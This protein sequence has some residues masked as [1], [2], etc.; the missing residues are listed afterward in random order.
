MVET[1]LMKKTLTSVI[2][3]VVTALMVIALMILGLIVI[4][5]ILD[6]HGFEQ[7]VYFPIVFFIDLVVCVIV[8]VVIHE[9]KAAILTR[10]IKKEKSE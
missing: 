8:V 6:H 9:I 3:D 10:L 2:S 7:V 5:K 4:P 1:P